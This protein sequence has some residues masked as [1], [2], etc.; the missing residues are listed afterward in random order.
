[1]PSKLEQD[2]HFRVLRLLEENPHLSQ[3]ELADKLGISLGKSN[4]LLRSLIEKG[5]VKI[6]ALRRRGD[7]LNKIAYLL[8][9]E[10]FQKRLAMTRNYLE[11]K[12]REY[13][14]LKAEIEALS[15]EAQEEKIAA[16]RP[17]RS[18]Q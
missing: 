13:D 8:T 5:H 10:G 4:Y 7:K 3:R 9:P 15:L 1:V 17:G 18:T 16:P 11:R 2:T 6:E 12:R 14:A